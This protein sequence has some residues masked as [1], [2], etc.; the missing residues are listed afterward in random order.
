MDLSINAETANGTARSARPMTGVESL[1]IVHANPNPSSPYATCVHCSA[2]MPTP[3]RS[4]CEN[5]FKGHEALHRHLTWLDGVS[6]HYDD[7]ADP[8]AHSTGTELHA[9]LHKH[10]SPLWVRVALNE[11]GSVRV[12]VHGPDDAAPLEPELDSLGRPLPGVFRLPGNHLDRA[13]P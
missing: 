9:H 13:K 10:S 3:G 11:D 1:E 4:R 8:E 2:P 6:I 5:N 7:P 12:V